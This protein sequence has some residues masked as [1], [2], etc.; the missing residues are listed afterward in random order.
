MA[1]F[2]NAPEA[3]QQL[4]R[5]KE[6]YA[7]NV[8][9]VTQDAYSPAGR[10]MYGPDLPEPSGNYAEGPLPEY[11]AQ[12]AQDDLNAAR[13]AGGFSGVTGAMSAVAP[14]LAPWL[15]PLSLLNAGIGIAEYAD[16]KDK[17][18]AADMWSNTG[19]PQRPPTTRR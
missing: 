15:M 6:Q 19:L 16:S 3:A 18:R 8:Q 12:G 10:V 5:L 13:F 1:D 4:A 17:G 7:R 9:R 11:F 2:F 14:E